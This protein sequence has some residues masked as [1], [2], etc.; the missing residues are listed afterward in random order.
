MQFQNQMK[1]P[2]N[3]NQT[4]NQ[5]TNNEDIYSVELP[6][7]D[8]A[9]QEDKIKE[10]LKN[11]KDFTNIVGGGTSYYA[12]FKKA[13][14]IIDT[15]EEFILKRLLFF[16]DGLNNDCKDEEIKA[17]CKG[18]KEKDVIFHIFT[19]GTNNF[20]LLKKIEPNTNNYFNE[21]KQQNFENV[22]KEIERQFTT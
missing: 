16:T 8:E 5:T 22:T 14:E 6:L 4:S 13:Y 1:I 20:E 19:F 7:D 12:A 17:I 9:I 3:Y 2:F 15:Q 10:E 11:D 21:Q 18:M